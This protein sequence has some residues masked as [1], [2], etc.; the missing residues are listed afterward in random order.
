MERARLVLSRGY[1]GGAEGE[2]SI[3]IGLERAPRRLL[4][5]MIFPGIK[6]I[7]GALFFMKDA[8]LPVVERTWGLLEWQA[9]SAGRLVYLSRSLHC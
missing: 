4:Y 5:E 1:G 7:V 6:P 3:A 8:N 2:L 9:I